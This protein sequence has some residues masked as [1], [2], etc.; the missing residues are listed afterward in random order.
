MSSGRAEDIY[1][2]YIGSKLLQLICFKWAVNFKLFSKIE[3]GLKWW[4]GYYRWTKCSAGYLSLFKYSIVNTL[5]FI[6]LAWYFL[7]YI[8][9]FHTREQFKERNIIP[10]FKRPRH[11]EKLFLVISTEMK[12]QR[13]TLSVLN[14]MFI[15]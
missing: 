5:T 11:E 12:D 8:H 1:S 14:F 7:L 13:G 15:F 9:R 4:V 10:F 6:Y 2:W 3:R